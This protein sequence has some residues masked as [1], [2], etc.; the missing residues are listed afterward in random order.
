MQTKT[1]QKVTAGRGGQTL[2]LN[3]GRMQLQQRT[4]ESKLNGCRLSAQVAQ[5][6]ICGGKACLTPGGSVIQRKPAPNHSNVIQCVRLLIGSQEFEAEHHDQ[7][8]EGWLVV[9]MPTGKKL[10]IHINKSIERDPTGRLKVKDQEAA[11]IQQ[12]LTGTLVLH[13][14]AG[15]DHP[16]YADVRRGRL[17]PKP[18]ATLEVPEFTGESS[19]TR[20]IPFSTN[21]HIATMAARALARDAVIDVSNVEMGAVVTVTV[22]P[23][24]SLGVFDT[25]E[26][27][28]LDPPVG[29]VLPVLGRT[30][31]PGHARVDGRPLDQAAA[32]D[33]L[34][35][36]LA[37][38]HWNTLGVGFF[39]PKTPDGIERMRNA[40]SL[41]AMVEIAE[42]K[43][44]ANEPR[45]NPEV[46]GLYGEAVE[47]GRQLGLLVRP[48]APAGAAARR[49]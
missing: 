11:Y 9:T 38:P 7:D 33:Y 30:I 25:G 48:A 34:R 27:Q 40:G 17:T 10:Y 29:A 47:L 14:G 16:A 15:Q 4:V 26:I 3:T 28:V 44:A 1:S 5:R 31:G 12:Y 39:G 49:H 41:Q 22:G 20:F 43:L 37:S 6:A 32:L 23:S 42:A 45:R 46:A 21:P 24:H 36:R 18:T 13:R 35:R 2:P 8:G 19:T